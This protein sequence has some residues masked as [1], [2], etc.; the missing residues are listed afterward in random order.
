MDYDKCEESLHYIRQQTS[1]RPILGLICGSGLGI[2]YPF[3]EFYA[4]LGHDIL[5]L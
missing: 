1:L 5:N 2:P 3:T 4:F